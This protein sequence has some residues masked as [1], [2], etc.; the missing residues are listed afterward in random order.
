MDRNARI[1]VAYSDEYK[2]EVPNS[3]NLHCKLLR[4]TGEKII[5]NCGGEEIKS[6]FID[7]DNRR[8]D[9]LY[10]LKVKDGLHLLKIEDQLKN[11]LD[12]TVKSVVAFIS[13]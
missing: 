1:E 10:S 13:I 12:N 3:K 9:L 5:I 4:S 6:Q 2:N 8:A 7:D 11:Q